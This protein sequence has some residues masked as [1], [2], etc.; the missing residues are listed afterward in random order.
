MS[1]EES[2]LDRHRLPGAAVLASV[3]CA[4][5]ALAVGWLRLLST[6][7][8]PAA[9]GD[10][11]VSLVYGGVVVTASF[12]PL[13]FAVLVVVAAP[14]PRRV[15]G[16]AVLVYAVD[17]LMTI[18]QPPLASVPASVDV[19]VL[20]VPLPRVATVLAI[21]TAA[22]LA[23]HGGYERL[24]LAAGDADQHPIFAFVA[25]ES[26]A[27]ALTVQRGVVVAGLA[28]VVSAGGLYVAGRLSE[29]LEAIVRPEPTGATGIV[30][31][32]AAAYS[33]GIPLAE[34]PVEWLFELS[35]L[36]AV[37]FVTG[38]RLAARDLLKGISVLVGV[39]VPVS[40]LAAFGSTDRA[41]ELS[42]GLAPVLTP[43]DDVVLLS[44]IA[45]AVWLAFHGGLETIR[46]HVRP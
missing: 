29:F 36:L 45:V 9:V 39:Q 35:F 25:D 37:L 20:A 7:R 15:A 16:G 30:I 4:V 33:V 1:L 14:T 41:A 26:I 2:V 38:P 28:G 40:L 19:T 21:A 11:V 12:L 46:R 31:R 17:L 22:W 42:N 3:C 27:P 34:L 10:V 5:G 8:Y 18:S 6:G 23:F 24:A 32:P 13:L 43:L 44:D